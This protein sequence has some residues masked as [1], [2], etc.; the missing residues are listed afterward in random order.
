[1]NADLIR[2]YLRKSAA[3]IILSAIGDIDENH[4]PSI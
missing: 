4:F 1:M 2:V 3:C